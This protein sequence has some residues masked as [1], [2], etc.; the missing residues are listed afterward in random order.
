[1]DPRTFALPETDELSCSIQR[2]SDP[3]P[4]LVVISGPSGV[5][6]DSVIKRMGE[7]GHQFRFVV[8]ATDRPRRSGEVEG[9][10]YY[11]VSTA[12]FERM[13]A[14]GELLEYAQVYGQYK[15]VP[16]TQA[17][18]ALSEGTDV[19]MR[20]DIQGAMTMRR[21]VPEAVTVFL[22]PPS[23]EALV[24]R[25]ERR[26]SDSAEQVQHRL[27]TALGEMH[28]IQDLDYVVVNHEGDLDA[29]CRQ[30]AAIIV[31]EKC[32]ASRRAIVL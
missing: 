11:F 31:A 19:M 16:K 8:T 7:L 21:L 6:K 25:L 12:Q 20:L 26:A 24:G 2:Y 32:R 1:M 22:S 18:Q 14:A 17:R 30:I 9:V 13:I 28:S 29:A 3:A 15:G 5:G 23:L 27:E 10:D 4:L